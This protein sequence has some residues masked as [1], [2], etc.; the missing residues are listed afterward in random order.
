M[1]STTTLQPNRVQGAAGVLFVDDGGAGGIP[2]VFTH[3]F[4]GS[5]EHWKNQLAHLRQ[6]R[7]VVA[8]DFRGHGQSD[9]P[10]NQQAYTADQLAEDI[11]AVADSL[12]LGRFVLVGHS[13]GG[14]ASIAYAG[15]HPEHVAGLV[16]VGTPGKT[17]PEQSKVV[18]QSLESDAYDKVMDDYMKRLL[19]Q[20]NPS[21]DSL[22]MGGIHKVE[23]EQSISIIKAMF[24]FDPLPDLKKFD[25]PK[26]IISTLA[27]EKQPN[28]LHK[29]VPEIPY[30]M[31]AGTSHWIMLD[32]P[33]EFNSMLD[34]FLGSVQ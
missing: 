27:E 11:S 18:V 31:V 30:K 19:I 29:L 3:S 14:S 13:M 23:K 33:E 4:G 26:L 15:A 6:T 17:P 20:A 22:V 25:G 5:T 10:D 34:L 16:L 2:V 8:F 1:D 32:K 12:N 24:E 7:R 28:T 9:M 21:S